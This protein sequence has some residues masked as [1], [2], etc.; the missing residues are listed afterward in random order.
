MMLDK[1][2]RLNWNKLTSS[3]QHMI[4][5]YLYRMETDLE[6]IKDYIETYNFHRMKISLSDIPENILNLSIMDKRKMAYA[7]IGKLDQI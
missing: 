5:M 6:H 4:L 2:K 7:V 3:D 1:V